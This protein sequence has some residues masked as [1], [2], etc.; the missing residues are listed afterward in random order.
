MRNG[1]ICATQGVCGVWNAGAVL[2][3][4]GST[5][6]ARCRTCTA[7]RRSG[8]RRPARRAHPPRPAARRSPRRTE[9]SRLVYQPGRTGTYCPAQAAGPGSGSRERCAR[10]W[11][12]RRPPRPTWGRAGV[13]RTADSPLDRDHGVVD[14]GLHVRVVD[15][16]LDLERTGGERRVDGDDVPGQDGV[17]RCGRGPARSGVGVRGGSPART[18]AASRA[19]DAGSVLLGSLMAIRPSSR[20]VPRSRRRAEDAGGLLWSGCGAASDGR[21]RPRAALA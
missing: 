3:I 7:R 13:R 19:T 2:S 9:R 1:R 6:P 4:G 20:C 18:V 14:G 12:P 8:R 17:G 16:A 10:P 15:Q 11:R 5:P 21:I